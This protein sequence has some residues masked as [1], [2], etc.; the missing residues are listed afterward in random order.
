VVRHLLS[1][2]P[3]GMAH[4]EQVHSLFLDRIAL[5]Q[6][7]SYAQGLDRMQPGGSTVANPRSLGPGPVGSTMVIV[8]PAATIFPAAGD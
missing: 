6:A 3:P 1:S 5:E 2:V 7:A 8:L 4:P